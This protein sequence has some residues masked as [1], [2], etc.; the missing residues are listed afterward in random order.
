[1]NTL[2][3]KSNI[4]AINNQKQSFFINKKENLNF[5]CILTFLDD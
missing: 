4:T 2:T 3:N 1:M 5:F